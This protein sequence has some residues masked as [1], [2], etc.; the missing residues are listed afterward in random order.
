MKVGDKDWGTHGK[1]AIG[2]DARALASSAPF[3]SVGF[4]VF[5]LG[6]AVGR[7]FHQTLA[8]LNLEPRE[9]ALLRAVGAAEGQSQ[10]AIG[11]RLQ[12]PASRMVAFVDALQARGLL[13][14]R[15]NPLDRRTRE[16]H[17]TTDGRELLG[18]AFTLAAGFEDELCADLAATER[19]QLLDLLHRVGLSPGLLFG[20][21]AAHAALTEE[22]HLAHG[23]ESG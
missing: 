3:R 20:A 8:P 16:L 1:T 2:G 21:H 9:F 14:R 23:C 11:G 17:L 12:I 15:H 13:E 5:S 10:Q 6:Y 18:A 19:E 22:K 4:T 7:R